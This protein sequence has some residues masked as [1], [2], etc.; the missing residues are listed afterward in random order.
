DLYY[1]LNVYQLRIPPLRE[2]SEDIE[3]ILMIFLERAKNERGCRVKAIAPDALTI[4]RNHNW[5]GNVRE[6]HNVVEWL[7]I[8]C[9]EEV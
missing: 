7:T 9:K 5:P 1:R 3:P 8:T 2:R 6:L 4:L